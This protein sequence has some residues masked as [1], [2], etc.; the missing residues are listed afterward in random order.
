M[1]RIIPIWEY[2]IYNGKNSLDFNVKVSEGDFGAAERDIQSAEIPGRNG[3]LTLDNGRFKN[4]RMY[5]PAYITKNFEQSLSAF[6]NHML[7]DSGYHR[8]EDTY[9]PDVYLMARYT[10]PFEPESVVAAESGKF[11]LEFDRM[12]Q[13]WL[14]SGEIAIP[15]DDSAVVTVNNP[16]AFTALPLIKVTAGTGTITINNTVVQLTANN[17]ATIIDSEMQECYEGT[18]NRNGDLVLTTGE[19][20]QLVSGTNTIE[21]GEDMEIELIPRWWR[22]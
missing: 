2:F 14:K 10:G 5:I 3:S 12:P 20:P 1:S 15:V 19:F 17:G 7:Q 8:Y 4:K 13:K 21:V 22:I 11:T 16:T 9:H 6:L 18:T